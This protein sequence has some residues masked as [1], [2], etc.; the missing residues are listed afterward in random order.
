MKFT[1]ESPAALG[2]RHPAEFEPQ[3][4]IWL[5]FPHNRMDFPGKL[6]PVQ[7][8][9]GEIIRKLAPGQK[10]RIVVP[11]EA[12]ERKVR[13]IVKRVEADAAQVEYF[14]FP[15]DRGWMRDA[16]PIFLKRDAKRGRAAETVVAKFRFNGWAKYDNWKKDDLIAEAAATALGLGVVHPLIEG[17]PFVLEGGAIDV[18]G[19]G[20]VV[21]TEECLLDQNVQ[22]RNPG[23][24]RTQ[25]EQ[26]LA[27]SLGT[28]NVL[29]LG[30]GIA[31]D[32]THGHVDDLCRFV[33]P[34]TLVLCDE[35]DPTDANYRPLKEN[36][37]RIRDF[38]LE[39]G[40]KPEVIAL[41]MPEP[42][43][44]NGI[45]L[46]ASY[47]NFYIGNEVVLVPTFNDPRDRVALGILAECFPDRKICGVHAVD[48]VWGFGTLHCL[49]HEQPAR[50]ADYSKES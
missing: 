18:N 38:R 1:P 40:S 12:F 16:G 36:F 6:A 24:S 50:S 26:A 33:N 43:V 31:G 29:W 4:A 2:F 22:V 3:E 10:V 23:M 20:T 39:D 37:E 27:D 47:A 34:T 15:T 25:V 13:S 44:F 46:P 30:H 21:T 35:N 19:R 48:L 7:W 32:D 9:Y 11:D 41:P 17:R 8:V 42:L 14:Q 28:K 45:R 49:S 5:G